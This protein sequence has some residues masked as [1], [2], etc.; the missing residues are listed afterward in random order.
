[1]ITIIKLNVMA[2]VLFQNHYFNSLEIF[3]LN[4]LLKFVKLNK[5]R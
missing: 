2:T 4:R 1:M 5:M 3:K